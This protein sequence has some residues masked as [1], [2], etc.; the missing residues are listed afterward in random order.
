MLLET[1]IWII[2]LILITYKYDVTLLNSTNKMSE[3]YHF[4]IFS[5]LIIYCLN[6]FYKTFLFK[7]KKELKESFI[8]IIFIINNINQLNMIPTVWDR[9]ISRCGRGINRVKRY[10]SLSTSWRG[11]HLFYWFDWFNSF[12]WS[13]W[14]DWFC[15]ST[16]QSFQ[17]I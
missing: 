1:V 8:W 13:N 16:I 17:Q 2:S 15:R 5:C 12:N 3:N 9:E 14:F 6:I 11:L 4:I 10:I 7:R